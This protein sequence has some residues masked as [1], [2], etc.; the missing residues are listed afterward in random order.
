MSCRSMCH[1]FCIPCDYRRGEHV[2]AGP[3][4]A[5]RAVEL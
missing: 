1:R 4:V 3:I 5:R 2:L